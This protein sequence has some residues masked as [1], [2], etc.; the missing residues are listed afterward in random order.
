MSQQQAEN[1]SRMLWRC[2]YRL[3]FA[4]PSV[5]SI[6]AAIVFFLLM[7][8]RAAYIVDLPV[9]VSNFRYDRQIDGGGSYSYV[10]DW[11]KT[12]FPMQSTMLTA[13]TYHLF[14][15]FPQ[16]SV[17]FTPQ[18]QRIDV[19]AWLGPEASRYGSMLI[20]SEDQASVAWQIDNL[21]LTTFAAS[22]E[23]FSAQY[24]ARAT[25]AGIDVWQ[26]VSGRVVE[27]GEPFQLHSLE[28]TFTVPGSWGSSLPTS[29]V[30]NVVLWVAGAGNFP[31][32]DVPAM[33]P[34][35]QVVPEPWSMCL[36]ALLLAAFVS[37]KASGRVREP[38]SGAEKPARLD[39]P[40]MN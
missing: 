39:E 15:S 26:Y 5:H 29:P 40:A 31:A 13:G 24:P 21:T 25:G 10:M 27:A 14:F 7:P 8:V 17:V 38:R 20:G 12:V 16:S 30:A 2:P 1:R 32:V 11:Q 19:K 34:L 6:A 28:V 3:R 4:T 18:T 35:T 22:T 33:P 9:P 23:L 36:C 37:N